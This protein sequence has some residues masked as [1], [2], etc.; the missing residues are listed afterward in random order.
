MIKIIK[1]KSSSISFHSYLD[2]D[3]NQKIIKQTEKLSL[4]SNFTFYLL[5]YLFF[6]HVFYLFIDNYIFFKLAL[7]LL[8]I[9]FNT[10]LLSVSTI[11]MVHSYRVLGF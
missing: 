5:T 7:F 11:D 4:L 6:S 9:L 1:Y 10:F 2:F 3:L 8:F